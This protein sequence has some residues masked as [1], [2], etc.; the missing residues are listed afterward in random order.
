MTDKK[1][2][3]KP[4]M[5]LLP[6]LS[7]AAGWMRSKGICKL[8][9]ASIIGI[10]IMP[11]SGLCVLCDTGNQF[12]SQDAPGILG[13][14]EDDDRFGRSL[15]WGDFNGDGYD[16][17]AVGVIGEDVGDLFWAGAVNVIYGTAGGLS[18]TGNQIWDQDSPG[19]A[20][21]AEGGDL[22]GEAVASGDFNGDGYDDLA[23]G[24]SGETIGDIIA[25]GA[26]NVIYGTA[27][28]LA[29]SGNQMWQQ[30]SPGI[31]GGAEEYDGFG[32]AVASGDF[33]GD[34]YDDLAVGVSGE[35]VGDISAAG[36]VNV[37]YGSAG[38]LSA[39]GDQIWDQDSAGIAGEA[40][41]YDGFG[42]AVASGD[43]NGD[44]YD[45]LAVGVSGETIGNLFWA[46]A[47]NVIYGTAGGLSASG[48]QIWDQDSAGIAGEAE[49]N[50]YFGWSLTLGD[51]NGDGYEDLAV[52]V[53]G[54]AI[55]DRTFAGAVNVIYGTAG[56]L[57]A[58]GNQMWHQDSAGIAGGAEQTD[59]F[60][61]AVASGDFNG[62]GYDDLAI[63]V[64]LE[65]YP[66]TVY[67][68]GGVNVLYSCT[69]DPAVTV[70]LSPD[71]T[72]IPRG[73][74]LGYW[75]TVENTTGSTQCFDYW[76][77]VNL[78]NGNKYPPS[79]E[80]FGPYYL[81]LNPYQSRSAHLSHAIP[82]GAPLGTYTYNGYVGPYSTVWD[83]DH[84]YFTVTSTS[85]LTTEGPSDWETTVDKDFDE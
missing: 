15:T 12:W 70:S 58:T 25:A 46:G 4:V 42:S 1:V 83:E 18:A 9:V 77:N 60:G 73:G 65:D 20:G 50:D 40:E 8:L 85:S 2:V 23:V 79:G 59:H 57:A 68:S 67:D 7:L 63:G 21:E 10:M 11:S 24:V 34:G 37:I 49:Q 43:F 71:A 45:D 76:T 36:A 17:L 28:G 56:G 84:F 48:D 54:E 69:I 52:G 5:M 80:L 64:P 72:S 82:M 29:A 61:E 53:F 81:C 75:I 62:D 19:I 32:D 78:P 6:V 30:N 16:D 55:G 13:S 22:F 74:T 33:N 38:G 31:A 14:S 3:L 47:V 26:V 35:D 39:S 66:N 41:E 44:G 27:G 51:F